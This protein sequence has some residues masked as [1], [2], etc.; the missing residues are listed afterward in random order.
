MPTK[1]SSNQLCLKT[2]QA[3][4][5]CLSMRTAL[6]SPKNV[7]EKNQVN[8]HI[9]APPTLGLV[10]FLGK[11]RWDHNCL[12]AVLQN[13]F[14]LLSIVFLQVFQQAFKRINQMLVPW[15]SCNSSLVSWT[16]ED[17]WQNILHSS[18][19]NFGIFLIKCSHRWLKC[20]VERWSGQAIPQCTRKGALTIW[21]LLLLIM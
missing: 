13:F 15:G 2:K 4:L 16:G 20:Q 21:L 19:Y 3:S 7:E 18:T 14:I 5:I 6:A 10:P 9:L 8:L 17:R 12:C 1:S 11:Q